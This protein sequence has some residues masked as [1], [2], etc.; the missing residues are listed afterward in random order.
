MVD[1]TDELEDRMKTLEETVADAFEL[2]EEARDNSRMAEDNAQAARSDAQVARYLA[3]ACS[4]DVAEMRDTLRAHTRSLNALRKTQVEQGRE[5]KKL[6][7]EV[8]ELRTEVRGG[9]ARHDVE[10]ANLRIGLDDLRTEVGD[11]RTEM[12]KGFAE[13]TDL[14]KAGR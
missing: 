6:R 8:R 4:H 9:F 3:T 7:G 11:L 10:I 13:L 2:A 12:R 1:H 5:L 14:I